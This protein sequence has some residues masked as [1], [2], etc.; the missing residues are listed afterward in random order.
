MGKRDDRY[1]LK[2]MIELDD[3]Y[4]E[5]CRDYKEKGRLKKREG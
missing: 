2:D 5:T 3:A 4:I 1:E